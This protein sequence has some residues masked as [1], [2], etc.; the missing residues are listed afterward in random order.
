MSEPIGEVGALYEVRYT[1]DYGRGEYL[2]VAT[3]I[4]LGPQG[5]SEQAFSLRPLAGTQ[6]LRTESI[7]TM[8][9]VLSREDVHKK[10]RLGARDEDL[11]VKEKVRLR[12]YTG[13]A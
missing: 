3:M 6:T 4:Y 12:K 7:K 8:R 2:Y 5:Q 9:L 10:Y 11:P 1:L 13:T